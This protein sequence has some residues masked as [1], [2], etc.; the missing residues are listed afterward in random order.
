MGLALGPQL[1]V[2]W[3]GG[4]TEPGP[5]AVLPVAVGSLCRNQP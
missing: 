1:W 2:D 3:F 4:E 5:E